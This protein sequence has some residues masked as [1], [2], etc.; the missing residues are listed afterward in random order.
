MP[1]SIVMPIYNTPIFFLIESIN[2]VLNQT[3]ENFELLIINDGSTCNDFIDI[4]N[5]Y[6]DNRIKIIHNKHDYIDS[7]NRG[8][9]ISSGKY[10][11]RLDSDDIMHPN[12]LQIQ[13]DF[14]ENHSDV[15]ICGTWGK[16]YGDDSNIIQTPCDHNEIVSS[17]LLFNPLIHSSII[18]RRNAISKVRRIYDKDYLYAEDYKLW[19]NLAMKKCIFYNLPNVLVEYR[20]SDVQITHKHQKESKIISQ[21]IKLEYVEYVINMI[22]IEKSEWASLLKELVSLVND[23]KISYN[24]FI[25]H[26]YIIY[27]NFLNQ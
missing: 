1:I 24:M 7:L 6:H 3:F 8:I 5:K 20:Y 18:I 2:S 11:A 16:I 4:I 27:N 17:L 13:W 14:M 21:K 9:K 10:I 22:Q 26:I 15:D 19:T 23:R 12:R 25:H